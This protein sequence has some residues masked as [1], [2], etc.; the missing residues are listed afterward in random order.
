MWKIKYIGYTSDPCNLRLK[1]IIYSVYSVIRRVIF[2]LL[3][4][5]R[6]CIKF[7][8]GMIN[9]ETLR[10]GPQPEKHPLPVLTDVEVRN[11]LVGNMERAQAI[12]QQITGFLE[13]PIDSRKKFNVFS[14]V[15]DEEMST[16]RSEEEVGLC[17][18][19]RLQN[20]AFEVMGKYGLDTNKFKPEY[21]D[22]NFDSNG[23]SRHNDGTS[24]EFLIYP[25][26]TISGVSFKR[27]RNYYT[28]TG[29]TILVS[30]TVEGQKQPFRRNFKALALKFE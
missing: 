9:P 18:K 10:R 11:V 15:A 14:M 30:W 4:T 16:V 1:E 22:G 13:S 12:T 17:E 2:T 5:K 26:Q 20:V 21:T 23:S 27:W 8:L 3:Q 7:H 25:S 19:G 28:E 29:E 24:R 6:I